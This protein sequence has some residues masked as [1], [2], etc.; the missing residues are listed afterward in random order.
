M[1]RSFT[2]GVT[3]LVATLAGCDSDKQSPV[4]PSPTPTPTPPVLATSLTITGDGRFTAPNQVRQFTV[5]AQ[6]S[7][8]STRDATAEALWESTNIDVVT[9]STRGE[10]TSVGPGLATIT[11][12]ALGQGAGS[13]VSVSAPGDAPGISGLYRLVL[14]TGPGCSSLPDWAQRREYPA[15]LDQRDRESS[16]AAA[17]FTMTV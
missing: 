2:A 8:G 10:V 14:T 15:S 6:M 13:D 1:R 4:R 9:V 12:T 7:E 5:A 16:G 11:A 17:T 3:V